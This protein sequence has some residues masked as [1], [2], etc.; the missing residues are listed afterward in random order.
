[1]DGIEYLKTKTKPILLLPDIWTFLF[2]SRMILV[3]QQNLIPRAMVL[4]HLYAVC[5]ASIANNTTDNLTLPCIYGLHANQL[6]S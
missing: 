3:Q 1:M 5:I 2:A 4:G 6:K